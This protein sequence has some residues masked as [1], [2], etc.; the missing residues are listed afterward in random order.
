[1]APIFIQKWIEGEPTQEM[2]NSALGANL[3]GVAAEY[4][5]LDAESVAHVPSH[6]RVA[7]ATCLPCADGYRDGQ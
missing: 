2:A 5:V 7:E 1:V 3:L 4:V 6:L